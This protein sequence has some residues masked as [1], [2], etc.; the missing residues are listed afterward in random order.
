M[1]EGIYTIEVKGSALAPG[2]YF[3]ILETETERKTI[4]L[5]KM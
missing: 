1:D 5:V 2:I 4:K 3:C